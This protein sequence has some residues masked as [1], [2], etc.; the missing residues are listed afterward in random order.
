M[1]FNYSMF[2]LRLGNNTYQL[3]LVA[4]T[5]YETAKVIANRTLKYSTDCSF[6]RMIFPVSKESTKQI[7]FYF[8]KFDPRRKKNQVYIYAEIYLRNPITNDV[9]LNKLTAVRLSRNLTFIK[10]SIP[11]LAVFNLQSPIF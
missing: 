8:L 11:G 4:T 9:E 1:T 10:S 7:G 6:H 5:S 3:L 2:L